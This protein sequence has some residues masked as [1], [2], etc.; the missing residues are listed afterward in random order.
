MLSSSE[1]YAIME[2]SLAII[3]IL[4]LFPDICLP[5]S[6]PNEPL[7]FEKQNL[8]ITL[9]SADGTKVLLK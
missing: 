9:S 8:T 1:D 4:Q 7:G 5:P 6:I 2:A 3:R